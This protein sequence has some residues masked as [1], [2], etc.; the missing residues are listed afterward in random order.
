MR[1]GSDTP[2]AGAEAIGAV[3]RRLRRRRSDSFASPTPPLAV[4]VTLRTTGPIRRCQSNAPWES[5][6][7]RHRSRSRAEVEI[8]EE[9]KER[10]EEGQRGDVTCGPH[11]F[12]LCVNDEWGPHICFSF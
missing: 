12:F 6:L 11:N 1:L 4:V 3:A 8:G 10:E 2:E 9:E 7:G 5:G